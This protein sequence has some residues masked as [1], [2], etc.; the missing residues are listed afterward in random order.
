MSYRYKAMR[1][2]VLAAA[3]VLLSACVTRLEQMAETRQ[4]NS[5]VILLPLVMQEQ[6]ETTA[7]RVAAPSATP[8][9]GSLELTSTPTE[10]P[11]LTPQ[12]L[13]PEGTPNTPTPNAEEALHLSPMPTPTLAPFT[14]IINRA[15]GLPDAEVFCFIVDRADGGSEKYLVPLAEVPMTSNSAFYEYSGQTA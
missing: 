15:A 3:L 13:N 14:K 4:G 2:L 5:E 9:P 10:T 6:E 7:A 12:L 8:T 1:W 11:W